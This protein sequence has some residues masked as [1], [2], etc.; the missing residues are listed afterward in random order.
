MGGII[1]IINRIRYSMKDIHNML[2]K[3]L[4]LN[5]NIEKMPKLVI[6]IKN[7]FDDDELN[8][9]KEEESDATMNL[10][11]D[12][13]D[14][15]ELFGIIETSDINFSKHFIDELTEDCNDLTYPTLVSITSSLQQRIANKLS[16]NQFDPRLLLYKLRPHK[17]S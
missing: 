5:K 7:E 6:S 15:Y 14:M 8:E 1:L 2:T 17:I 16:L 9:D 3:Q 13:E 10:L 4:G 11:D 12:G